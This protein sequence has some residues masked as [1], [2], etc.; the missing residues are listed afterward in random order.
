MMARQFRGGIGVLA[1]AFMLSGCLSTTGLDAAVT[2]APASASGQATPVNLLAP[3]RG[4]LV[5]RAAFQNMPRADRLA[6]LESEYRALEYTA[7]GD[8]VTWKGR[9]AAGQVIPS[10]PYRVGSQDCRQ[11]THTVVASARAPETIRGTACR[12][13]DGSW[14]LLD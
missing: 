6:A 13:A 1:G 4:G 8:L 3:L 7:P 9:G 2:P 12:N 14:E 10:Q 5:S 11:Y